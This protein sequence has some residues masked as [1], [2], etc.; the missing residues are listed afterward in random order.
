LDH[1]I[2]TK[3]MKTP[4][5]TLENLNKYEVRSLVY[6]LTKVAKETTDELTRDNALNL[7]TKIQNVK[8]YEN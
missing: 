7:L 2:K 1:L 5:L 3:T 4:K 8:R 6:A